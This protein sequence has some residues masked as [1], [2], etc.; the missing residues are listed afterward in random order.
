[1]IVVNLVEDGHAKHCSILG[2]ECRG[3]EGDSGELGVEYQ[4]WMGAM[5]VSVSPILQEWPWSGTLSDQ[6]YFL[7]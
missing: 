6:E 7:F 5:L 1:M 4:S 3:G 2:L